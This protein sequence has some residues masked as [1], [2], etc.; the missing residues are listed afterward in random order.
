[1][2]LR[3]PAVPKGCS[4][5]VPGGNCSTVRVTF[6]K[7]ACALLGL[8]GLAEQG[9][10]SGRGDSSKRTGAQLPVAVVI[11]RGELNGRGD[12]HGG[13]VARFRTSLHPGTPAP[14]PLAN[15]QADYATGWR[16]R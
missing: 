7:E 12:L 1:M 13:S 10:A 15:Q 9:E 6:P 14:R 11:S 2:R 3:N 4:R 8:H 16:S 5:S